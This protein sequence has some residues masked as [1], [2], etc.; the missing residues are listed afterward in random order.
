[1]QPKINIVREIGALCEYMFRLGAHES[2][3]YCDPQV[4]LEFAERDDG[5]RDLLLLSRPG[6]IFS[7]ITYTDFLLLT[8]RLDIRLTALANFLSMYGMNMFE[9]K[10]ICHL[11]DFYYR[12]GVKFG[13]TITLDYAEEL[14]ESVGSGREHPHTYGRKLN[15]RAFLDC[16]RVEC[17]TLRKEYG[18][19]TASILSYIVRAQKQYSIDLQRRRRQ[20]LLEN[21]EE[22]RRVN[23]VQKINIKPEK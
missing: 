14:L 8:C 6:N 23:S 21:R 15:H 19:P 22:R 5:Y 1:M 16:V 11:A 18:L 3:K 9:K 4:T 7:H 10:G 2:A 13:T 17:T 20:R 12:K